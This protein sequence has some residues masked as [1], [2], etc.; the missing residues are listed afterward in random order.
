MEGWTFWNVS[1][2][3]F[4]KRL[5]DNKIVRGGTYLAVLSNAQYAD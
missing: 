3:W 5:A 1:G 2:K 4:G